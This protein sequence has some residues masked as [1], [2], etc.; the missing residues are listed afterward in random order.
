MTNRWTLAVAAAT[1]LLSGCAHSAPET[2]TMIPGSCAKPQYSVTPS[3][4]QFKTVPARRGMSLGI[5]FWRG[6]AEYV[7]ERVQVHV[8]PPGTPSSSNIDIRAAA[9]PAVLSAT[10]GPFAAADREVMLT[11]NGVDSHG[12]PLPPG[13]Y[14]AVYLIHTHKAGA[15]RIGN[16]VEM[17]GMITTLDWR[18]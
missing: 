11:F 17:T 13:K 10:A 5:E 4:V 6:R 8:L 16:P 14:P 12:V 7:V 2:H 15:C 9:A 3:L 18:G 1:T